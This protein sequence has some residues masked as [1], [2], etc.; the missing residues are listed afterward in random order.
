MF[1]LCVFLFS[2]L[3]STNPVGPAECVLVDKYELTRSRVKCEALDH[4][5]L[6]TCDMHRVGALKWFITIRKLDVS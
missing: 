3:V 5:P 4:D 6:T 2:S 1:T